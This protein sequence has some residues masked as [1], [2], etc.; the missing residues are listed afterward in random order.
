MSSKVSSAS[1]IVIVINALC[2]IGNVVYHGVMSIYNF[3]EISTQITTVVNY[4][5]D[6][7]FS[8]LNLLTFFIR[9]STLS[10]VCRIFCYFYL[11][12]FE[13]KFYKMCVKLSIK[14]YE[15]V[16]DLFGKSTNAIIKLF[17]V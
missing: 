9:P 1:A 7:I 14:L 11:L 2:F 6:L 5:F 12:E 16:K 10:Y 17:G 15:T 13:F 4:V 3:G 8:S